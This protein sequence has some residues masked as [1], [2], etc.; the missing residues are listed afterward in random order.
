MFYRNG[1]MLVCKFLLRCSVVCKTKNGTCYTFLFS[2][3]FS[4]YR[5]QFSKQNIVRHKIKK[6][7]PKYQMHNNIWQ[8]HVKANVR[9]YAQLR[10]MH[11]GKALPNS[12]KRCRRCCIHERLGRTQ[13]RTGGQM[14]RLMPVATSITRAL[15]GNCC[16]RNIGIWL[17]NITFIML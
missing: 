17:W 13:A 5:S 3:L 2:F 14:R 10:T 12:Q 16:M 7:W 6:V 9:F 1:T 15:K 11:C 8:E 4:T